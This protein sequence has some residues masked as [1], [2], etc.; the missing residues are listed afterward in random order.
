[1]FAEQDGEVVEAGGMRAVVA[2]GA[3]R[4]APTPGSRPTR[5]ARVR[6]HFP[7]PGRVAYAAAQ[8]VILLKGRVQPGRREDLMRF[9]CEAVRFYE[10]PGGILTRLLWDVE[11]R[12]AFVELIEYA[13]RGMY[14]QDQQRVACDPEMR[15]Y[16]ERWH[17]MLTEAP[18]VET[19]EDLTAEIHQRATAGEVSRDAK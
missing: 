16:L 7:P 2:P 9:L 1:M 12:D 4:S 8:M 3:T 5:H 17:Q 13:G 19:Y 11:D 15:S 14:E 10:R 18:V 6:Q